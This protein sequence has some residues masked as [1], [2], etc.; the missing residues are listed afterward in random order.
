M[1]ILDFHPRDELFHVGREALAETIIGIWQI[2][3]RRATRVFVHPDPFDKFVS[4]IVYIPRE[5]FSTSARQK[6]QQV[7][8]EQLDSTE[9]EYSTQF[10]PESVLVRIYLVYQISNK[11]KLGV[12]GRQLEELVKQVTRGWSDTFADRALETLGG[13]R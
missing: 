3:E 5:H 6:I 11:K 12:Q 10:L 1:A 9:N 7:I 13:S 4:C 8:G 2:Y